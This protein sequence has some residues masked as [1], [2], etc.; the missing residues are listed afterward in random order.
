MTSPIL[1]SITL[2]GVDKESTTKDA[3]LFSMPL[4]R[5]DSSSSIAF[6]L[7]G[8]VRTVRITGK[9]VV[10]IEGNAYTAITYAQALYALV[11]GTQNPISYSSDIYTPAIN[12][13]IQ[14]VSASY[15]AGNPNCLMYDVAIM[16]CANISI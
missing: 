12:V 7:M 4:P 1:G 3:Q 9:W 11:A 14:S 8:T 5:S 10:G 13:I 16:E 2:Y 15:D 6:D